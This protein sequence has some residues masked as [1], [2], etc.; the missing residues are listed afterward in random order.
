M[1]PVLNYKVCNPYL[2]PLKTQLRSTR[3][4]N[5][6]GSDCAAHMGL[7][8]LHCPRAFAYLNLSSPGYPLTNAGTHMLA[9]L[10]RGTN[11]PY[12]CVAVSSVLYANL[13]TLPVEFAAVLGG[14]ILRG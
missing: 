13:Q 3:T 1:P 12:A 7:N 2:S 6:L 9:F 4:A 10:A 14:L 8:A 11:T 5:C